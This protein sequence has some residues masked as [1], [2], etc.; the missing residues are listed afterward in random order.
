MNSKI[1]VW[2]SIAAITVVVTGWFGWTTY[3]RSVYESFLA[4]AEE[5][6]TKVSSDNAPANLDV[7]SARQKNID[8][9]ISTLNKIPPSSGDIYRKAQERWN[10][11]KELDAQLMQRMENEKLAISSLAKAKTLTDEATQSTKRPSLTLQEWKATYGKYQEAIALLEKI[12]SDTSVTSE[13]KTNLIVYRKN[14]EPIL[15]EYRKRETSQNNKYEAER[16]AN[17]KE[18]ERLAKLRQQEQAKAQKQVTQVQQSTDSISW[19]KISTTATEEDFF[20]DTNSIQVDPDKRI[21]KMNTQYILKYPDELGV[22]KSVMTNIADC[23]NE[24]LFFTNPISY[25]IQG[26]D[27]LA[28]GAKDRYQKDLASG[29]SSKDASKKYEL[30]LTEISEYQQKTQEIKLRSGIVSDTIY[31]FACEQIKK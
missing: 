10:K 28:A 13:A 19:Q 31:Q 5:V 18:Q 20:V 15:S 26:E 12:P 2:G 9:A 14:S 23:K 17:T 8:V 24:K 1:V 7:L 3:Q 21:V 11:L 25:N 22:K 4:S 30:A 29:M 6:T 27:N 16:Q